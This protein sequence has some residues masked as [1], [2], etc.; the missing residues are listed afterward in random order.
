ME[1]V[2]G[3][4]GQTGLGGKGRQGVPAVAGTNTPFLLVSWAQVDG[5]VLVGPDEE[6]LVLL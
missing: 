2:F 6:P 4:E 5:G 3:A 1:Q